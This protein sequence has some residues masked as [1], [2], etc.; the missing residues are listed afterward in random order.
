MVSFAD[1]PVAGQT[2]ALRRAPIYLRAVVDETDGSVNALDQLDDTP[3]PSERV[4]VYRRVSYGG[5]VHVCDRGRGQGR[6][7]WYVIARYEH[8]PEVDGEAL[9]LTEAWWDWAHGQPEARP[10]AEALG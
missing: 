10:R 7:G 4:H 2:L 5:P 6:S 1:G 8:M 9:R 3:G